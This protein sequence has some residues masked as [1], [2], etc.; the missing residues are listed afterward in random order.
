MPTV[1]V[2]PGDRIKFLTSQGG[3]A[4][5]FDYDENNGQLVL[6]D[7]NGDPADQKV[8]ALEAEDLDTGRSWQVV[9]G[10]RASDTIE[11]NTTDSEIIVSVKLRVASDNSDVG[12]GLGNFEHRD[13]HDTDDIFSLIRHVSPGE[14]YTLFTYG[15]DSSAI[16]LDEWE[17]LR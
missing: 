9:T 8:G 12:A 4:S 2:N 11:T 3:L 10:S 1:E 6:Q 5:E 14:T 7:S 15:S 17:E 16:E 13:T